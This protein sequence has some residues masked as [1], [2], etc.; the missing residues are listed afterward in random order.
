MPEAITCLTGNLGQTPEVKLGK[1]GKAFCS[2]S[3]AVTSGKDEN[4]VTL[5]QRC[6]CFDRHA[7]DM[8]QLSK[9]DSVVIIGYLKPNDWTD[10]DGNKHST[11]E[12]V[13]RAIGKALGQRRGEKTQ[14]P[15]VEKQED[16]YPPPPE[17]KLPF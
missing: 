2:F 5:W 12:L 7:E 13:V 15:K 10:K 1:S 4:K 8:D 16:Y 14:R 3:V 6:V 17:D 9:G 11:S